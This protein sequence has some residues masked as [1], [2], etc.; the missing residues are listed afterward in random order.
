LVLGATDEDRRP[1]YRRLFKTITPE[2][3]LT[4]I[5]DATGKG[6]AL[7]SDRFAAEIEAL[8][9]R[10]AVLKGRDRPRAQLMIK[11]DGIR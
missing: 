11:E 7:G 1:A 5:R 3:E 4:T 6:W 10:R 9:A 8:S 2:D